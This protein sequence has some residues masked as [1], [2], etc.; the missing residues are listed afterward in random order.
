MTADALNI[1]ENTSRASQ[2]DVK[3]LKGR[4]SQIKTKYSQLANRIRVQGI[5]L[6]L[7]TGSQPSKIE[8]DQSTR[9]NIKVVR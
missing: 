1:I 4:A 7:E 9:D 3:I 5:D 8:L 6:I 2:N